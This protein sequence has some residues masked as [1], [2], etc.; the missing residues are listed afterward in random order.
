MCCVHVDSL[1]RELSQE[2]PRRRRVEPDGTGKKPGVGGYQV[3][4]ASG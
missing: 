2:E 1:L 3:M 4:S